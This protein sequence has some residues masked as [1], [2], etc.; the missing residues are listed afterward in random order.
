M[1]VLAASKLIFLLAAYFLQ[2][3][4]NL[5]LPDFSFGLSG[6]PLLC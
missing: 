3:D 5:P 2:T 1:S 6:R 4:F